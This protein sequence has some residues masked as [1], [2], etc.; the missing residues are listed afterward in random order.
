MASVF[1]DSPLNFV[2]QSIVRWLPKPLPSVS[3]NTLKSE[4]ISNSVEGHPRSFIVYDDIE[5]G[6]G[7]NG[8]DYK[9]TNDGSRL[10]TIQLLCVPILACNN[11]TAN[12]ILAR[13]F[14]LLRVHDYSHSLNGQEARICNLEWN[15]KW[16]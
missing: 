2:P 8:S 15:R 16:L 11:T 13:Q 14:D 1:G 9:A 10:S 3:V 12:D 5:V 7:R 6:R 4:Y